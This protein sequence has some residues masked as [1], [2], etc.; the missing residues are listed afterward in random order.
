MV[1]LGGAFSV[2]SAI[3]VLAAGDAL[4][5]IDASALGDDANQYL[6]DHPGRLLASVIVFLAPLIPRTA[7]PNSDS[8]SFGCASSRVCWDP[9]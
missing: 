9:G 1:A 2:L 5:A 8:G 3:V 7:S 6:F 4:D